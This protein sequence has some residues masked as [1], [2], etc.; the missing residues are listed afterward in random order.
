MTDA[1]VEPGPAELQDILHR[2]DQAKVALVQALDATDPNKFETS[3]PD[4]ETVKASLER[5]ADELNFYY[6]RLVARALNLP[7]PPCLQRADYGSLREGVMSLH[8]AHRRFSNLLHDLIA[9]DLEKVAEDP[10]LGKFTLRQTLELAAAQYTMRT[11]QVQ[12]LGGKTPG[13]PHG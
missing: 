4:S 3:N 13:Q 2:L 10:E 5:T 11:H 7:Q 6:G 8:V 9:E 1:Q 12:R